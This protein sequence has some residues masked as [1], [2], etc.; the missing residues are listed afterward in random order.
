MEK[1]YCCINSTARDFSK[2][3][4]L[5]LKKG[6]WNGKQIVSEKWVSEST[7]VDTLDGSAKDYQYHWRVPNEKGDFAAVGYKG[8]YIF[9]SPAKELIIL[10]L[11]KREKNIDWIKLFEQIKE[12][13]E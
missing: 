11:G 4:R 12:R 9:V 6:N 1:T 10:R 5:Y 13:I 8:Q 2:I 7:K 3:G